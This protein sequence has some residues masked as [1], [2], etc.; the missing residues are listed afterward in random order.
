MIDLSGLSAFPLTPFDAAGRVDTEA[1]AAGLQPLAEA[2]VDSIGLL[3]STGCY[4]YLNREERRR[5]VEAAAGYLDGRIPLLVGI[6]ALRTDD[7]LQLARDAGDAGATVGLLA[8]MSYT[9]LTA[10]EVY[11]HFATVARESSLPLC[12][13]DNPGTTHFKFTPE[14]VGRLSNVEGII[15]VKSP[16][17]SANKPHLDQLRAATRIGF[18]LGYSGDWYCAEALLSGADT[19]YCVLAGLFP[20]SCMAIVRAAQQGDTAEVSRINGALEPVW[21]LF[22]TH[23]SLRVMYAIAKHQGL[24]W[25]EPPKPILPLGPSAQKTVVEEIARLN[26]S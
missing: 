14:L 7:A 19:W 15:A 11:E 5:A 16:A 24:S 21:A 20:K 23:S 13:Y 18:S 1:L 17:T 2:G 22:R 9:Q 26:L 3:G 10:D 8:P 4:A 12:I 6:G 25:A